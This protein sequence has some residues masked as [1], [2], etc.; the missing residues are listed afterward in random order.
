MLFTH[1]QHA[2][3][4][5]TVEMALYLA[6]AVRDRRR[7]ARAGRRQHARDLDHPQ[8]EPGRQRVR[9]RHRQLPIVAQEP[10][11]ERRLER[12]RHRPQP[13]LGLQ[14]G[15]L[16]RLQR[17]VLLGDLP[18]PVRR[19]R[20]PRPS[21]C[22]TSSIR[23]SSAACSRSRPTSTSTPTPSWCCGRTAT[24]P[25]TR[26]PTLNADQQ[27]TFVTLGQSMAATN[28]YT[29][30]QASDLYITDGSIDDWLWAAARHLRL[31]VRDV[32][33]DLEPG[34]LSPGRGDRGARRPAIAR[35][36]SG[37]SRPPTARTG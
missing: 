23:G 20:R 37:C 26:P 1:G 6:N 31:H 24:R 15:L 27:S 11:A 29:A 12:G 10:P 35:P 3:E 28:G 16:R 36:C 30:E 4:H 19:S 5:L 33:A 18:R 17:H 34:L 32:P 7:H 9:R 21:A 25:R 13:Q 2:R 14:L 8:P 22:A